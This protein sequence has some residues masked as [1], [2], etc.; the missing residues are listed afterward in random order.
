MFYDTHTA[1]DTVL[2]GAVPDDVSGI[3][4]TS[5]TYFYYRHIYLGEKYINAVIQ[6]TSSSLNTFKAI[7]VRKPKYGNLSSYN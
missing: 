2:V 7:T 3:I 5:Y 6:P 4:A 1:H